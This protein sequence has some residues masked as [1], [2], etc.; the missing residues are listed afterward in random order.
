MKLRERLDE[1]KQ[2]AP[3]WEHYRAMSDVFPALLEVVEQQKNALHS[4]S[5][6]SPIAQPDKTDWR[7]WLPEARV[8]AAQCWC[9]PETS[10]IE[11]DVRLAEAVAKAIAGWMQEAAQYAKNADYW[12]TLCSASAPAAPQSPKGADQRGKE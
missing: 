8:R 3:G 12:R 10:G 5:L 2:M 7:D 9:E 1:V 11:M 6:A 4:I